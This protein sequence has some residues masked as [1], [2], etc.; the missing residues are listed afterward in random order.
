MNFV[1]GTP[2]GLIMSGD[3]KDAL[4]F[5]LS[6]VFIVACILPLHE[7]SHGLIA[8]KLGD[9]T[10]KSRGRLTLNPL[11]HLDPI[12]SLMIL[13][14]GFGWA[15]PVPVNMFN[16]KKPKKGMA[17]V[18][19]A[20]PVSNLIMGFILTFVFA[21]IF[22]FA[23]FHLYVANGSIT[24]DPFGLVL[25]QFFSF[26]ILINIFLAVFNFIPIPPLDGSRVLN[27]FLPDRIYYEIMKY[28]QYIFIGVFIL[29]ATG[30]LSTPLRVVAGWVY[31][32]MLN[33]AFSIFPI[34]L[35]GF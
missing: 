31:N 7:M 16:F 29:L 19:I 10:A 25:A 18:A 22:H 27:A 17:L 6:G 24:G 3:I 30:I 4:I 15:K 9:N 34:H 13:F 12:G 20:G 5:I 26:A 21:I 35:M 1:T 8:Y 28:E 14:L 2:I 11:A 33:L 23:N 32:G